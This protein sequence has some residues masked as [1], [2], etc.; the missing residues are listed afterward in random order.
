M[1]RDI[2][3]DSRVIAVLGAHLDRRKA[4][5]WVPDYLHEHGYRVLP[6]NPT[7]VGQEAWGEPFR[8]TLAAGIQVVQD[9]CT[10][11]DHR[12]FGL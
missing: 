7:F 5:R 2:L 1:T 9:R 4:A 10:Y 11:A 8:A 6:V 3:R 12:A